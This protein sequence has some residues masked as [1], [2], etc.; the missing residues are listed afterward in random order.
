VQV[1]RSVRGLR[2]VR[3]SVHCSAHCACSATSSTEQTMVGDRA[4]TV[5]QPR[6]LRVLCLH[7]FRQTAGGFFGR[8][9]AFRKALKSEADFEFIDAP[10]VL[11]TRAREGSAARAETDPESPPRAAGRCWWQEV[12]MPDGVI[13]YAGSIMLDYAS[14]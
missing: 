3:A 6:K 13:D 4:S 8:T 1:R 9:R 10:V 2:S 14:F 12:C 7:G 5:Q 11:H